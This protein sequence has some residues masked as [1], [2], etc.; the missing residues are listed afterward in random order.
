MRKKEKMDLDDVDD[1]LQISS[2][3]KP[4]AQTTRF[5]PKNAKFAP[6][7]KSEP[8]AKP[9]P[10]KKDS[11]QPSTTSNG[12]VE[13][14]PEPIEVVK[15][16][17]V[18]AAKPEQKEVV[19]PEPMEVDD[20]IASGSGGGGVG[21]EIVREIDVYFNPSIGHDTKVNSSA[22]LY[23]TYMYMCIR[24]CQCTCVND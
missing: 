10:E 20:G 4:P 14:K 13:A 12:T 7:V 17:P 1:V 3:S 19:K 2:S 24:V 22:Y 11:V 8:A 15:P 9:K 6:R 5:A 16:E 21:D 23:M 18:E